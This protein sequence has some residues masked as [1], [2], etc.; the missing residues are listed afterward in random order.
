MR[1]EDLI[2]SLSNRLE[3]LSKKLVGVLTHSGGDP[4]SIG[5]AF[6]LSNILKKRL[7]IDPLF[8]VPSEISTHSQVFLEML[9]L[10]QS[11]N[12][13]EAD[14]F[15]ILDCGSPE[16]LDDFQWVL[17]SGREVVV[18]D[19]HSTSLESFNGKAE[20]F[21]SDKY[22]SVCEMVFDL[23]QMLN[24]E[25][26][27]KEAEALF[28]G[29]YY[30]T[31]RLSVADRE[32]LSKACSLADLGVNPRELLTSLEIKMDISE[33]IARLKSALRMSIYKIN[34]WIIV[35]SR[36]GG[37]QS[38]SARGLVGLGAHVAMV[39]GE[40]EEGVTVSFRALKDFIEATGVNLGRDIAARIGAETGGY[41]GGHASAAKAYCRM[42]SVE[43]VLERCVELI[44]EKIGAPAERVKD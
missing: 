7:N 39:A 41:G 29:L 17:G 18:I 19:H 22:Q 24:Y 14:A 9:G 40:S 8:K 2:R 25:L 31:V 43:D 10:Q 27:L 11:E 33:R 16:Q 5:A 26:S 1:D 44:S 36:V 6:V 20:V 32:T 4:D 15:I 37:F 13:G 30:D 35:A 12:I 38:S 42:R 23:S 34:D 3:N 28:A 21:S